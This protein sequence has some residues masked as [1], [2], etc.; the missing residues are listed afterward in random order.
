MKDLTPNMKEWAFRGGIHGNDDYDLDELARIA[1]DIM[2]E[3]DRQQ[4]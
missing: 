2:R 1:T 4:G 3:H